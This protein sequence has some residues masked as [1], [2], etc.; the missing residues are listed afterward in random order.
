MR[1]QRT[2]NSMNL[3]LKSAVALLIVASAS[4]ASAQ[5]L[6]TLCSFS[7]TG[8]NPYAALTLGS[9]GY[10]YGTTGG[11]GVRTG[12]VFRVTTNGTLATL[13]SFRGT[14]GASPNGLTVGNDGNFYSTTYFGGISG[15]GTVFRVTTNGTLTTLVSFRGTNGSEP[16]AALALGTDGDF[17]GTTR[18]GGNTN[19]TYILGMGTVFRVTT[20]GTLATLVS[21]NGTNGAS[22]YWAALTLGSDGCFYG[23]TPVG[24]NLSL[25]SGFGYGTIFRVTTNGTLT[26]LAAFSSTN[27]SYPAAALTLGTDGNFYGTTGNGGNLSLNGGDGYGTIFRVTTNGTLTTLAAFSSTNGSYPAAA[28][29]LGTDG[30]FYGTTGN[31][32][33][34]SLNGGDGYGTIFRVTTNGT[35]TTLA[36]FNSTNGSYPAAAL[37]LGTDGNF[38]GTTENGGSSDVGTVF[39]LLLTPVITVQPQ[40]QTN[41]PGATVTFSANATGLSPVGYQWIRNGTNLANGGNI[42]GATNSMLTITSVSGSDAATY[43]AVV[44][45]AYG[46]MT[47]SNATLTVYYSLFIASQP[48]SQTVGLGSNVAFNVT[49]YGAPP[50]VF[51][52]YFNGASLSSPAIGTNFSSC[53]LTAVETNQAGNYTVQVVNG[54]G[55]LTSSNAVLTV[56]VFPPSIE[57]QPSSQRVM[58]GSSVSFNVSVIGTPPFRYQWQFNG[59]N[60]VNATNGTYAIQAVGASNTG[61]YCVVVTNLA[62]SAVS[63]N[64]F[65]TV[66]VP[67]TLA[68]QL[69]A[70]YPLLNLNGMLSSNFVVQYGTN[71]TG[72]NWISL[73]SLTNLSAS[74][75]PF[76]DPAG[77][78]QPKRFYRAFMQ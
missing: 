23:T 27:G 2:E 55:S 62:G 6:Q 64:A 49:V 32:G 36:A 11:S 26:T 50:L 48:Q 29:T 52:W 8:G 59:T 68:L 35:L 76:L 30:N 25:N 45:N 7:G 37:T 57:L 77:V 67:P 24:G 74:P 72:T 40:S 5:T 33:N 34:L 21:F 54:Y 53:T 60:L 13:V 71:L 22:P 70:G 66:V 43:R 12:T 42:S 4:L 3:P 18:Q 14:N 51:Q 61:D 65:L 38:Y 58:I 9:D 73:L 31:G 44:S 41:S 28:L 69:W 17:Y 56:K 39:R 20:N 10:F 46:S 78:G 19:S 16:E 15:M 63:S 47:S 1:P 75:Y